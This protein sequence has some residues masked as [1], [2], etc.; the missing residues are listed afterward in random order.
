M[1]INNV[2]LARDKMAGLIMTKE[3]RQKTKNERQ[4]K[5]FTLIE[6]L[7]VIGIIVI[8]MSILLPALLSSARRIG[9]YS[10]RY[11]GGD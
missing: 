5:A 9:A 4:L 1:S 2:V 11:H 3:E 8:L 10:G 7:V 6:L